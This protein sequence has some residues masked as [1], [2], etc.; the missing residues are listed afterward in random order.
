ML[1]IILNPIKYLKYESK[2]QTGENTNE[3]SLEQHAQQ[4]EINGQ[5]HVYKCMYRWKI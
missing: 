3:K 4:L 1:I 5:L 2:A